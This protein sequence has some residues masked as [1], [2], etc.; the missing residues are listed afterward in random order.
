MTYLKPEEVAP[1]L[2]VSKVTLSRWRRRGEGPPW[3][4]L[5][6][7]LIRYPEAELVAWLGAR[8]EARE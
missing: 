3:R 8:Q 6:P 7:R 5:G 4:R 2:G 1:L